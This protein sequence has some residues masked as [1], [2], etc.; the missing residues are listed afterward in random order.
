M[1]AR[2]ELV[3]EYAPAGDQPKA[4]EQILGGFRSGKR[5]QTLLGATGTGKTFTAANVIASLG[6]PTLVLAHNKT[7]AA[8]LY[9]ELKDFFPNNAVCYFVSY[10]D[11]YQPE[12]YIPQ[13]DIYIEKDA[14]INENIDRLRLAAT[15]AL[16]SREDVIIVASVSCIYGLGS[17]SDYKRMMVRLAKGEVIE[18]EEILLKLIDIQYQRNDI[19]FE[20]GKFRVRGDVVEIY[21]A[22]EEYGLRVELFGDEVDALSVIHPTTGEVLRELNELYIYP[23]KHFVTPEERIK[24]AIEG[25]ESELEQRLKEFKAEGKLL[26]SERLKLR[27]MNDLDM[28]REVGYCSGIE[29]YA[30]WFSG[31]GAGQPPYTLIDF[32]PKEFLCVVDESHVTLPQLRGMFAGDRSRKETL[33]EHGFRLPS[34]MDNR[35]LRFEEW[36]QFLHQSLFM[37]A[38][39]GALE[40]ERTGGEVVEQ[41]I[42]PTGLVDPVI[43]IRPARGQV[44]DLLG[45]IKLRVERK[46]RVLVT[47]LTKRMSEDLTNYLKEQGIRTKWLHSE[48]DAIERVTVLRELREGAFDVLVGVNLLREGLDLPEVALVAILDADKEGFLRSA[49]SL[50]QTIGRAA[51]N[52]NAEVIL[53]ADS[54]TP[55]M[56]QAIDETNRRRELQLAYNAEHGI[57]PRSVKTAIRSVIEDEIKAHEIA[58]EAAGQ[59]GEDSVTAEYLEALQAEMLAAAKNLEFE[60]AAQL[61]DK[62]AELKGEKVATPQVKKGRGKKNSASGG[63]GRRPPRPGTTS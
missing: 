46:D 33:V 57:T 36:E 60:R 24:A 16:V 19:E 23:A 8:Q 21:P 50:I 20:R 22:S 44:Q 25:I 32:F 26:E 63:S 39:P 4:I 37:S 3:S 51:R 13:R 55:S 42:R 18:R 53:Y 45:E 56:Q 49:T 38:T 48:L 41:V 61:R 54:T 43:H 2:F 58:Q 35:P 7:L 59:T 52:V 31:R 62:I 34:A 47:A 10:Y 5:T 14:S 11:Y 6:L 30:R 9:K 40:L 28:L 17:P 12:A 29:N 1:A 27:T 15:S